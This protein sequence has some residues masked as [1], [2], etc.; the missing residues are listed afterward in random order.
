[1]SGSSTPKMELGDGRSPTT[2]SLTHTQT[3]KNTRRQQ[4]KPTADN[5]GGPDKR[6]GSDGSPSGLE[7]GQIWK[8]MD[9]STVGVWARRDINK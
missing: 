9:G 7:S 2:H 3:Q 6:G 4:I 5:C 1:M 8:G